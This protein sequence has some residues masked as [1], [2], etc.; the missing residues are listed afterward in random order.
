MANTQHC[1]SCNAPVLWFQTEAGKWMIVDAE[2]NPEGTIIV[3]AKGVAHTLKK[4][5]L[6]APAVEG[7]SYVTHW[8]TRPS[9]A[10]HKKG[11]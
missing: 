2:P 5:D 6:F 3:D 11:A 1:R 4:A 10:Q 9:R 8:A 7:T